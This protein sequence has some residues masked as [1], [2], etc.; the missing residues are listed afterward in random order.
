MF[1]VDCTNPA[2]ALLEVFNAAVAREVERKSA[3]LQRDAEAKV[4]TLP[5]ASFGLG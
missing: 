3:E 2:K 1:V 5:T 4:P